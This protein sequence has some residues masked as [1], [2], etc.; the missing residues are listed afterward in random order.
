MKRKTHSEKV[1]ANDYSK[2]VIVSHELI[3]IITTDKQ[4]YKNREKN[5]SER[6]IMRVP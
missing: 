2:C 6:I 4:L 3:Y 1:I 5:R